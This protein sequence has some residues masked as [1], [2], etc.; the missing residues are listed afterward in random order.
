MRDERLE[1]IFAK[2]GEAA[3]KSSDPWPLATVGEKGAKIFKKKAFGFSWHTFREHHG[4][5]V[6]KTLNQMAQLFYDTGIASSI[7]EVKEIMPYLMGKEVMTHACEDLKFE[8]IREGS[9]L[10]YKLTI[11]HSD[12]TF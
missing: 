8:E 2:A 3:G 7:E 5:Y 6:V 9:D 4:K 10:N 1:D 11:L 12:Y